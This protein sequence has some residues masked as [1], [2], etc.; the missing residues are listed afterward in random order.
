MYL[1]YLP[2][3]CEALVNVPQNFHHNTNFLI[4]EDSLPKVSNEHANMKNGTVRY[5]SIA[6]GLNR[7]PLFTLYS[8]LGLHKLSVHKKVFG[9]LA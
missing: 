2:E 5:H 8:L 3:K 9:S 7:N 1:S 6:I 4:Q